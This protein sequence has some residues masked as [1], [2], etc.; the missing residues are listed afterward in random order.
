MAT[1]RGEQLE[2]GIRQKVEEMKRLCERV[3]EQR[4]SRAPEGR[5]SPKEILSHLCGPEG[6]G[7]LPILRSFVESETPTLELRSADPFY[8]EQRAQMSFKELMDEFEREY[9]RICKFAM[10]L[11]EEQLGRK[12]RI[13]ELKESPLGE[14]PTLEAMIYGLG[15]YHIKSHIDHMR[16]ILQTPSK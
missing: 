16:E 13:P 7:H 1:S 10:E 6:S 4:G 2:Q 12:A 3:D 11:T 15:Q 14:Y 5:W 9:D 8:T